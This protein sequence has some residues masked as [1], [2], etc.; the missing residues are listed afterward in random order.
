[1]KTLE[2]TI[3]W[4]CKNGGDVEEEDVLKSDPSF[5]RYAALKWAIFTQNDN[6]AIKLFNHP[7][8]DL[9][10]L[11][12][13]L[14]KMV[15]NNS[16]YKVR[17]EMYDVY[18]I[19]WNWAH[20]YGY[21]EY[22]FERVVEVYKKYDYIDVLRLARDMIECYENKDNIN[23]FEV[24]I[25]KK[26][27]YRQQ[28]SDILCERE[29]FDVFLWFNK[30]YDLRQ[31]LESYLR[32][33]RNIEQCDITLHNKRKRCKEIFDSEIREPTVKKLKMVRRS[34][35]PKDIV[36]G[37]LGRFMK[38]DLVFSYHGPKDECVKYLSHQI[39][40]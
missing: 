3:L 15:T 13:Y 26:S 17:Y 22:T 7:R 37:V 23:K 24:F 34:G 27:Y 9:Y 11:D 18:G 14:K 20:C 8:T 5:K 39:R 2:E 30:M 35:L 40:N 4:A 31:D 19:P 33:F 6:M 1:M 21:N 32:H 12:G 10:A 38:N 28:I 29:R 16:S 25:G 36:I